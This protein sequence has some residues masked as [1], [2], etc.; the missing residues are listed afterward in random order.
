[1]ER[2]PAHH[3]EPP[4]LLARASGPPRTLELQAAAGN[5]AVARAVARHGAR[6]VARLPAA[7]GNRAVAQTLAPRPAERT[8]ARCGGGTCACGGT[9]GGGEEE[10]LGEGDPRPGGTRLLQRDLLDDARSEGQRL[11]SEAQATIA[12]VCRQLNE[13]G[14]GAPAMCAT[15][16]GCPAAFCAPL[17]SYTEAI[18][19]RNLIK[20]PILA[21][22]RVKVSSR[23]V[24]LWDDYL[25]WGVW[26]G[27]DA[28]V[29]DL[30]PQFAVDFTNSGTTAR[31]TAY[32]DGQ[33]QAAL[34]ASR[35]AV[36][37]GDT[38]TID[39]P[40]RIP[41]AV[42]AINDPTS[43][44]QMNFNDPAEIPGNLAGG[45]GADELS[46]PV[47]AH[48]SPQND[49]RLV[50]GTARVTGNADGTLTV[51]PDL[52]FEVR[53]TIDLCPGDCGALLEQCA[54]FILSRL[55]ASGASGD[56]AF[57]V[58]FPAPSRPPITIAAPVGWITP[59]EPPARTVDLTGGRTEQS[60]P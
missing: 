14:V 51:D 56:I 37:P 59:P 35:P 26:A 60:G 11:W 30:T 28:T 12:D 44:R 50:R 4:A 47:G 42:A 18:A 20:Q 41:A 48:P 29:R 57:K 52:T 33:L 6:A 54:T 22:I 16:P 21:G 43:A 3:S 27:G 8:L 13:T 40:S 9:C 58:I 15:N 32:L 24:D 53:D 31:T 38:T 55:E 2:S 10:L 5:R 17:P 7:A 25:G 1:M 46:C 45:I 19:I 39:V 36:S 23:V 49:A 34:T